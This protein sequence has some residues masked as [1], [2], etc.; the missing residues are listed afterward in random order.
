MKY[1]KLPEK[2]WVE[3]DNSSFVQI[4][5]LSGLV[6]ETQNHIDKENGSGV[7]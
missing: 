3:F 1:Y 5:F 6:L 7:V 2:E 4:A